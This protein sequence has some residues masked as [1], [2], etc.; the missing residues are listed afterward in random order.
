[1]N[2][3]DFDCNVLTPLFLGG[4]EPRVRPELRA[5]SIRGAM[6]Y[7][8]RAILGG[9]ALLA[10]ISD[11]ERLNTL[12]KLESDVFGTT[13]KGSAVAVLVHADPQPEIETF[14]KDRAIRTPEGDFL[15]T[16]KD[17]LLWSMAASGRP[18]TPRYQPD[19]EYIK[20][21]TRFRIRL[22]ARTA[23][24]DDALAKAS[25]ALWLLANLGG[26]GSRA[27][28]G[29]GS[30][31]IERAGSIYGLTFER[32]RTINEL[33]RYLSSGIRQCL[34]LVSGVETWR[35]FS[36]A[37]EYDVLA[38]GV[39]E[40]WIVS[41]SQQGWETAQ[42]ALN[43]IGGKLRD[44]RSHRSSLGHADHDEVLA[45]LESNRPT[46]QIRRAAFGLPIPFRYSEGGPS[47]VIVP[48]Q[49]D[50]RV[51]PLRI[52][53]TRLATDRYVGMLT[54]FKSRFLEEGRQ[55]QLQTRRWKAPPPT[56]YEVI[57]GFIQTFEV[58]QEVS[59]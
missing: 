3:L 30:L 33:Q 26:L 6:R 25:A 14:R 5:P 1:M 34:S 44:Y 17:Y 8:Y 32:C 59:L 15:P 48:E 56:N 43:G 24:A 9:S 55:L 49:G 11:D 41:S 12:K 10:S 16:G 31:E 58:R 57:Q 36:E 18:G 28:R 39:A 42:E 29:A 50:R 2:Y 19:R 51:S 53:I 37:P 21:G 4:A 23:Q 20:P 7:W 47:D 27:N 22:Q 54:L 35:T 46:P 40:V 45:W 38:P 52:R 13:E